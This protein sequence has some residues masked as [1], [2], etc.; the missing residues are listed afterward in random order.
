M[1]PHLPQEIL[2]LIADHLKEEGDSLVSCTRVCRQWQAGFEPLIY[3]ELIH[4]FSAE[5]V[6]KEDHEKGMSL[7]HFQK[8]TS[9]DGLARRPLIR[10]LCYHIV[11]PIDLQDWQTRKYKGYTLENSVRR[12]NDI[13]FQSAMSDL[14][15]TLTD[16]DPSLRLSIELELLG[17][18][19]GRELHT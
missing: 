5:G 4:V 14:F 17:R 8:V 10:R 3:S 1:A 16:W 11:V 9:G 18:E 19:V 12:D 2:Y 13:A 15:T 6:S 7:S